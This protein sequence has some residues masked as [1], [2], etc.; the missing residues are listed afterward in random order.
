MIGP[1]RSGSGVRT[2]VRTTPSC[3][4]QLPPGDRRC[5]WEGGLAHST[6]AG[7]RRGGGGGCGRRWVGGG[8]QEGNRRPPLV[9]PPFSSSCGGSRP[10]WDTPAGPYGCA[11]STNGGARSKKTRDRAALR[12]ANC[13][14]IG[15]RT[16]G[17]APPPP[18][19]P[20]AAGGRQA[21]RRPG[22]GAAAR[23]V[24]GGGWV[25][26]Q[27]L[28]MGAVAGCG[29]GFCA[30]G[31]QGG[32][33]AAG[34]GAVVAGRRRRGVGSR[35]R[36]PPCHPQLPPLARRASPRPP[37]RVRCGR[38]QLWPRPWRAAARPLTRA[39]ANYVLYVPTS[40][41]GGGGL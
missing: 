32:G 34:G 16:G 17:R 7:A 11:P 36:P 15:G 19:A 8:Q 6:A 20:A 40:P 26:G 37:P 23:G 35:A 39:A 22:G 3:C 10:V 27:L 24:G 25:W 30:A 29:S 12:R 41:T 5:L 31:G 21:R 18:R 28:G 1:G 4:L 13:G 14:A 2:L 33:V 9:L 38:R